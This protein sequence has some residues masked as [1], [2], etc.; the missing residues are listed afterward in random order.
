[1][2]SL[3]LDIRAPG[4]RKKIT[5]ELQDII[6]EERC[7]D[8]NQALMELG[9]K[10]CKPRQPDCPDCPLTTY[11]Q[12]YKTNQTERFPHRSPRPKIP[13]FKVSVAVICRRDLFY[14]Q[15]RPSRGHLG[16][17]W[18]FPGGKA[19]AGE[20]PEQTL[21]RE[22]L[23]EIGIQIDIITKM[24][25]INHAYSHFKVELSFF[26]CRI[27]KNNRIKTNKPFKWIS[28]KQIDDLPFPG[29]NHKFFPTLRSY[30]QK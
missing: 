15:K 7:G 29:A 5:G 13:E 23:E 27:R 6:P 26:K 14:I 28:V 1:L 2:R 18:E 20:S 4:T 30:I 10:I 19:I 3:P 25:V 24:A 22:I 8:F 16:G 11:C 17:L 21:R 9:S 12:A